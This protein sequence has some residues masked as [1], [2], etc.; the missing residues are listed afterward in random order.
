M[1]AD[2]HHRSVAR[3]DSNVPSLVPILTWR[4]QLFERAIRS[5]LDDSVALA[6]RMDARS[7]LRHVLGELGTV[8]FDL[9]EAHVV[10]NEDWTEIAKRW[11]IALKGLAVVIWQGGKP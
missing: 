9:L 7:R 4:A 3:R 1:N 8:A 10:N 5:S 6:R 2:G 11:T